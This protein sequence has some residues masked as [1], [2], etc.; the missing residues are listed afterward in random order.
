MPDNYLML[1]GKKFELSPELVY[2]LRPVV[3]EPE[4]KSPFDRKVGENFYYIGSNGFVLT[5]HDANFAEDKEKYASANYCTD[6]S[7]LEQ[8]AMHETLNRLLWRYSE[9]HGG[10]KPWNGNDHD[11]WV[12]AAE[13][14][15]VQ[16]INLN[17]FNFSKVFGVT[18]FCDEETA[19]SAVQEIV[20]PFLAAHP[21]F[22][23]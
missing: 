17:Y 15:D 13:F 4:K 3:A 21:D 20:N 11:H 12:I 8:R 1:D 2:A 16:K 9:E 10:D 14:G 23:W 7:I 5:S 19:L 18:Y 22:V 6:K